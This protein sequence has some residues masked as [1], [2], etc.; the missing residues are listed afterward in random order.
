MAVELDAAIFD[1]GGVLTSPILESFL[2][3][4]R[5]IGI[6]EGSLVALLAQQ[7]SDTTAE[8]D[9]HLL[10]TGRI[11]EAEYFSRLHRSLRE[12][13]GLDVVFPDD[14]A[15]VRRGLFGSIRPNEEMIDAARRISAHYRTGLLTNNVKEWGGWRQYYPQDIFRVVVDSSEVGLRKPDPEIYRLACARVGVLPERA[16][17]VDDI[18]ANVDAAEGL[19]M[20]AIHFTSTQE[21]LARLRDL[22]PRAFA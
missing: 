7:Y 21:A 4:E 14:P 19:G 3:F 6:P 11:T 12:R 2:A 8:P 5:S 18:K 20:T 22:F 1:L 10:E 9:F 15:D 13:T 16:A 17:F